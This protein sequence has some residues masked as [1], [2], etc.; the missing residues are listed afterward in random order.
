[1]G[2]DGSLLRQKGGGVF[3]RHLFVLPRELVGVGKKKAPDSPSDIQ[4]M[5]VS[6]ISAGRV[7]RPPMRLCNHHGAECISRPNAQFHLMPQPY[8]IHT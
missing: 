3:T 5:S 6:V 8:H 4:C 7:T 1:M 2:R